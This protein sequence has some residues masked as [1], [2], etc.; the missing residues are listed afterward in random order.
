MRDAEDLKPLLGHSCFDAFERDFYWFDQA[1]V[2]EFKFVDAD[3]AMIAISFAHGAAV[4]CDEVVLGARDLD[5]AVV[6]C[7]GGY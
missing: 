5:D 4:V 7:A 3:H 1:V 2:V 6:A